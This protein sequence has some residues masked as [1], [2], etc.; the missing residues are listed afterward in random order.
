MSR[1]SLLATSTTR[2]FYE[3]AR[4]QQMD[5]WWHW[6]M[7]LMVV[8]ATVIVVYLLYRWDSVELPRSVRL[9]LFA[10]RIFAF[11]GLLFFFLQLE[12]RVEHKVVA[13]SRAVVLVDTSQSMGLSEP[14]NEAATP[15]TRIQQ[16]SDLLG[17]SPLIDELRAKHDVL[18]Y[19]FDQTERPV[20]LASF[21]KQPTADPAIS[22][23]T[24]PL[25]D[26]L[27]EVRRLV[28][29]AGVF[30]LIA[31]GAFAFHLL[32]PRLMRADTG[33]SWA[34][35]V[36]VVTL[37]VAVVVLA[38]SNLRHPQFS[39]ANVF[40]APLHDARDDAAGTPNPD[41]TPK[42]TV[43]W[44]VELNP[45][46]AETRLGD[47]IQFTVENERG[48]PIAG[49]CIITDGN[50]NAGSDYRDAAAAAQTAG[51][52]LY[53]VG[54]G[55]DQAPI[56]ARLVDIE[57]PAHV[58]PGDAFSI[59]AFLQGFG[60]GR[61]DIGLEVISQQVD[62]QGKATGQPKQLEQ[63]I[64]KL[65]DEG[66]VLPVEFEINMTDLGK[67]R[68]SVKLEPPGGDVNQADNEKSVNVRIVD[69]KNRVLLFAGGPLR[70]YLFLRGLLFRDRQ[71]EVDV[72]LQSS[73]PGAAKM[74]TGCSRNS[75]R[76][77]P[78]FLNTTRSSPSIRIGPPCR[79]RKLAC[80][81][82]GWRKKRA[83]WCCWRVR[84][85]YPNGRHRVAN[86]R[87]W[88]SF[89]RFIRSAS[90]R[91]H[92]PPC[93]GPARPVRNPGRWNSPKRASRPNFSGWTIV[94]APPLNYGP[95]F[96]GCSAINRWRVPSP[97]RS[98]TPA[99][100]TRQRNWTTDCPSTWLDNSTARD[101]SFIWAVPRC[102][103]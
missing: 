100:P 40:G 13:N 31:A 63:R 9:S 7:L 11:T 69:R 39:L 96:P 42:R 93:G 85:T 91:G 74:R 53:P 43:D 16:V 95:A 59:T 68:L 97:A 78:N 45:T 72:L 56:N 52:R 10:L 15:A 28:T 2:T 83:G 18:V 49:V 86:A 87:I 79:G 22:E 20:Q 41:V 8:M 17:S 92:H 103:G 82:D 99:S 24:A 75:P 30:L 37:V 64:I 32:F 34:L 65:G 36:T 46:G 76:R 54:A 88:R 1:L 5:Q 33:E 38:V 27:T 61:R 35:L 89:D 51:I 90:I 80:W 84:S 47:A 4:L 26:A 66:E 77:P 98:S 55:L 12:K 29:V 6:L 14:T 58:Y 19:R 21:P 60:I 67:H 73:P 25:A 62:A 44:A 48:G 3:F 81:N 94:R 57:A 50:G 70:E 102:G 101:A 71:V 23:E